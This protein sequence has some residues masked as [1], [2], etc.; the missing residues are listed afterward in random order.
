MPLSW[1]ALLFSVLGIAVLA[2]EPDSPILSDLSRSRGA[3][4]KLT[5]LSERY[6]SAAM[7]CLDADHYLWNHNVTTLQTLILLIYG[8]GHSHG[9]S[10]TLLGLAHHLAISIGCHVDPS[11]FGLDVVQREE[12]RRCWSGLMMLYTNQN[13]AMGNV[14]LPHGLL[15][16]STRPPADID[17]C[18]LIVNAQHIPP[19][20][21]H[22]TQMSYLLHKFRLYDICSELCDRFLNVEIASYEL[23]SDI[24]VAMVKEQRWWETQYSGDTRSAQLPIYHL[25]HLKILHS[26]ANHLLLL[27]HHPVAMGRVYATSEREWSESR[28]I[29]SAMRLL[30]IHAEMYDSRDFAPFKWYNRGIGS[31][32]AFHA[33]TV[34]F[35]LRG[36]TY[37]RGRAAEIREALHKCAARLETMSTLSP[38]CLKAGPVLR[39][40]L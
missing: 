39:Y 26:Y 38:L 5:E 3:Y 36:S 30:E 37:A 1:M 28:V 11:E 22:A 40:L 16:A 19:S 21:P 7:A 27:L 33:A 24:D 6:W 4:G 10:W 14:A 9:Q 2:L 25:A 17:D 12:R 8:I 20:P 29:P 31:F 35:G 32:H 15:H 34:L 13:T 18:E 23:V